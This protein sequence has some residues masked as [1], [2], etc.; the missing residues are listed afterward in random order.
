MNLTVDFSNRSPQSVI[1]SDQ[2]TEA[3]R[4]TSSFLFF[5]LCRRKKHPKQLLIGSFSK[6]RKFY[7]F[8]QNDRF[9][10]DFYFKLTRNFLID[11]I[12]YAHNTLLYD[13]NNNNMNDDDIKAKEKNLYCTG[14]S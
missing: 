5:F 10:T 4:N 11:D 1:Y 3:I 8:Y 6:K 12:Q 13:K 7:P 9:S 14:T 2:R